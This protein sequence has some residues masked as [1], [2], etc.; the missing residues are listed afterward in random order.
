MHNG[1]HYDEGTSDAT[2]RSAFL[3]GA[4]IGAGI[5]LPVYASTGHRAADTFRD[6]ANRAKEDLLEKGQETWDTAMEFIV[7]VRPVKVRL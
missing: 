4:L 3:A 2:G 1:N 7:E 5:A 6:Y